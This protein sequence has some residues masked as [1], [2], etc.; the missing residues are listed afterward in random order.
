MGWKVDELFKVQPSIAQRLSASVGD[1][2][3]AVSA[4]LVLRLTS[5]NLPLR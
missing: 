3:D 2:R 4:V 5:I 1:F